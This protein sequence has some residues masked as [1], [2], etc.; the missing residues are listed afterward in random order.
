MSSSLISVVS[1]I[2]SVRKKLFLLNK[3]LIMMLIDKLNINQP[4][5]NNI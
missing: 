5:V 3:K 4:Y 1:D 2:K